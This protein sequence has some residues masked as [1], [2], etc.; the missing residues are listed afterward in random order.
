M[1]LSFSS[2]LGFCSNL[3]F[4]IFSKVSSFIADHASHSFIPLAIFSA[5]N[6]SVVAKIFSALG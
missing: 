2:K 4:T 3:A 6:G 5:A 1:A